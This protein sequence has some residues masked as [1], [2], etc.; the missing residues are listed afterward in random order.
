MKPWPFGL[1]STTPPWHGF[2]LALQAYQT[3]SLNLVN[4]V[5]AL[6]RKLQLRLMCRLV[7]GAYWDSEIKRAQEIGLPHHPIFTHKHHTDVSYLACAKAL[8]DAPDAVHPQFAGHNASTI[9]AILQMADATALL[10]RPSGERAEVR[11]EPEFG[12]PQFE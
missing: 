12:R 9:A 8:L 4:H 11:G 7:K 6:A 1:R 2:R 10:P 3:R 5:I